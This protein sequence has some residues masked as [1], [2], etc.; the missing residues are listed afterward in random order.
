M[1]NTTAIVS[2]P[3]TVPF[4]IALAVIALFGLFGNALVALCVRQQ[5]TESYFGN[6]FWSLAQNFK[7]SQMS[8]TL[9]NHHRHLDRKIAKYKTEFKVE[10]TYCTVGRQRYFEQYFYASGAC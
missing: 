2:L 9:I 6:T 7:T 3:Y 1:N 4:S 5:I 10:S 8:H